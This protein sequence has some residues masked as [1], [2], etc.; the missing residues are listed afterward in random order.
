[1]RTVEIYQ[2]VQGEGLLTG[3]TS[4]FV[5]ASGCNLRCWYCDTPYASWKPEGRDFSVDEVLAKIDEF[6][7]DHVVLTGGEPMLF[8]DL[9]PLCEALR[10]RGMHITV[11]TAGTVHLPIYCDLMSISPKTSRS[12]PSAAEHP[13]WHALHE[14]TRHVPLVIKKLVTDYTY[15]FKFVVADPAEAEEIQRYLEEFPEI[16]RARVMLMPE[17]TTIQRLNDVASWLEPLCQQ[18]ELR[19]CPRKQIEWFGLVRGT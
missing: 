11:E 8:A 6:D 10:E 5:R 9:V 2:S 15:Q 19:Y 13:T 1:M 12:V 14:K 18:M 3:T 4:V 7:V 16:D 17:G